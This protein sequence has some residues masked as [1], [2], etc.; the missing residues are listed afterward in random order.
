MKAGVCTY[1][2]N[3]MFLDGVLT[4]MDAIT[5]VGTETEAD[6][7]EPLTRYWNPDRDEDDQAREAR[8]RL[9]ELGLDVSCYTLDSDFAIYDA[10]KHQACIDLCV[11]RLDTALI[12]KTDTIR[13]DPRTS[14]PGPAG[15]ANPDE[16]LE[17]IAEGMTKVADAA[18]EKGIKVGVENHGRLVGRTAQTQKMVELV[19]R[20]N[21]GV[22]IDFTNF[23]HVYGEDHIAATR[24]LASHVV[25]AHAKDFTI[26]KTPQ[27]GGEWR[28]IPSGQYIKRAIGGEGDMQWPEL[29][30][31]LKNAGYT[32]TISLEVS[33]P[34]D[35]K[36][37]VTRG[38]A[39]LKRVIAEVEAQA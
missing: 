2:F 4:M 16:I 17:R 31:I 29:F 38:V 27:A 5:F 23:R 15:E 8:S 9:D 3:Q 33:D 7:F 18:A 1:C 35:I 13:L 20:S 19:N 30:A 28:Q 21:F 22:N 34:A 24:L 12:L 14:L 36:G 11:R 25:H 32:G 37:S 10:A 26:S 39:N 6:C